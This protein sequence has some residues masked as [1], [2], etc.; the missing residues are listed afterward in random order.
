MRLAALAKSLASSLVVFLLLAEFT[1]AQVPPAPPSALGQW[2]G[3]FD[4]GI[5]CDDTVSTHGEGCSWDEIAHAFLIPGGIHAGK[6]VVFTRCHYDPSRTAVGCLGYTSHIVNAEAATP[7]IDGTASFA[8]IWSFGSNGP[9]CSGHTWMLDADLSPK[10]LAVGGVFFAG[11][12]PNPG[13]DEAYWF[14]P[15]TNTWQNGPGELAALADGLWYSSVVTFEDA[16]ISRYRPL[17]VG[18]VKFV[19]GGC[20]ERYTDWWAASLAATPTWTK[21]S[22]ASYTWETYDRTVLLSTNRILTVGRDIACDD[23]TAALLSNP[24]QKI[25]PTTQTRSSGLDPRTVVPVG[26]LL[27]NNVVLMHTL[28]Q[29][30]NPSDPQP[31][32][33]YDLDRVFSMEG[34]NQPSGSDG[35]P[36]ELLQYVLE[37]QRVPTEA[38]IR[39]ADSPLR[40]MWSN[41]V[42]LPDGTILVV[43]GQDEKIGGGGPETNYHFRADRFDPGFPND[44]GTWTLLAS[45]VTVSQPTED[46]HPYSTPRGYHSV[47]LLLANGTVALMGGQQDG[48]IPARFPSSD[49]ED[50][51]EIF[52]PPY[53]FSPGRP[54]FAVTPPAEIHYGTPFTLTVTKLALRQIQTVCLIGVGAATHSFVYGQRYVELMFTVVDGGT[55]ATLT[56]QAPPKPPQAT[57]TALAPEG[58]YM[59]FVVDNGGPSGIPTIGKFVKLIN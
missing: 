14:D 28:K 18:G 6:I 2:T 22:D 48:T 5:T 53:L 51:I 25:D 17:V 46:W 1:Q 42:V 30:P 16:S 8:N 47:A 43:G 52:K 21:Y 15:A 36:V 4:L 12:D 26:G 55:Q 33:Q 31:L 20:T 9:F 58:M 59:L 39:K 38:W 41:A 13:S 34:A 35:D 32:S 10:M 56:V 24:V 44:A 29:N 45:T 11:L 49:P 3:P 7:S 23:T 57:N 50:T 37:Y 19:G 27:Y 54:A 40:R